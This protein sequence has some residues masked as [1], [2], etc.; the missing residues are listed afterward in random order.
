[1]AYVCSWMCACSFVYMRTHTCPWHALLLSMKTY[2]NWAWGYILVITTPKNWGQVDWKFNVILGYMLCLKL[3]WA[4][5][6]S[7]PHFS[8]YFYTYSHIHVHMYVIIDIYII[9]SQMH[10]HTYLMFWMFC[11]S[12]YTER[13]F[14][15]E[16]SHIW[17]QDE[18]LLLQDWVS[19]EQIVS[20]SPSPTSV[21]IFLF[22]LY[23]PS[24]TVSW[25]LAYR[26]PLFR[27]MT[28]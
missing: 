26:F 13:I 16:I 11:T 1:M 14:H 24:A 7:L 25:L 9:H 17:S 2:F 6:D 20:V 27:R 10:G 8:M 23:S 18:F 19:E 5:S 12:H 28:L 21:K 3:A 15:S 22:E 4:V